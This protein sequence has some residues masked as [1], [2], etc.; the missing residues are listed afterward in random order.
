MRRYGGDRRI[1]LPLLLILI[2]V[3]FLLGNF[4]FLDRIAL[5]RLGDLWPLLLVL[6]GGL[7]IINRLLAPQPARLAS[8]ALVALLV[9]MG[10]AYLLAYPV[11]GGG[12]QDFKA[13]VGSLEKA[14]LSLEFG[15]TALDVNTESLADDLFRAHFQYSPGEPAPT[16]T[17]DRETGTVTLRQNPHMNPFAISGSRH[18]RVAVRLNDRVTWKVRISGGASQMGLN[19][20]TGRVSGV[21]ISGGA[22]QMDLTLPAPHGTVR[23]A[24][25]GGA[26]QMHIRCASGTPAR[27]T[28]TGGVGTLQVND[29]RQTGVGQLTLATP[30]YESTA[31]RYD[32]QITGG[33]SA[34]TLDTR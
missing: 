21:E 28:V 13:S 31:D 18:D 22:S 4:G 7:L 24:I 33:A 15:A 17:V 14:E 11:S 20:S 26:S 23:V 6:I 30:G 32:I 34:V 8:M 29:S 19:L 9:I 12:L 3:L 25:S 2:G 27:I 5:W 1:V 16:G 10:S